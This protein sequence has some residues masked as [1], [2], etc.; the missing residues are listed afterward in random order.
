MSAFDNFFRTQ[1]FLSAFVACSVKASAADFLA[2]ASETEDE[3]A[4]SV[5]A[6]SASAAKAPPSFLTM[7]TASS[8]TAIEQQEQQQPPDVNLNRN[9]AFLLYGGLYQ[10]MFLQFLYMVVY[11]F[12]YGDSVFR[13]PLTILTDICAFGPFVTLP[14]AYILRAVIESNNGDGSEENS[15]SNN[16][17]ELQET[18]QQGIAKYKNHVVT[19]GLLYKYWSI[20]APAQTINFLFVPEHLR[21]FFVA[22]VSFFWVFLLSGISSQQQPQDQQEQPANAARA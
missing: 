11:P 2:Q 19:Q 20:W 22:F 17:N 4:S 15:N 21:V 3:A 10:G 9:V 1:P 7:F 8:T 12:L 13:V 6:T 5:V 18:L 16:S 14:L